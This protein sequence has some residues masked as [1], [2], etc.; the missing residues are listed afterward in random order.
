MP[1]L[2]YPVAVWVGNTIAT[3]AGSAAV[4][5]GAGG[6]SAVL[7]GTASNMALAAAITGV[8]TAAIDVAFYTGLSYAIDA[9]SRPKI[10]PSGSELLFNM[11]P[12]Y[13]REMIIGQRPVGGSMVARYSRGSNL[14][15]AHLVMQLADH[16]CTELSE[17]WDGGRVVRSTP[18]THGVRTEIT[19][20]SNSGGARVWMTWHDGRPGQTAD[21]DLVTKSAQDPDVVA[22]KIPGWSSDH[23]GA[24]C[25]YVHVEV[26]WDSDILT[27][28]PQLLFLVKGAPLYDRRKDTT[29]GGSGSHRLNDPSTWEYSTNAAVA[30]DH[31]LLGYQV[32]D[33][34]LAF[35]V[36][37]HPSEVPY[38]QFA[39]AAD[40][41]DED[42]ETGTGGDVET[43]ARYAINGVVSAAD[44]FEETIEAMQI[45]MAARVVD[46]GGRIGILGAEE[47]DIVV[48]LDEDDLVA[49]EQMQFAD[50]LG[51]ED[52]YGSVGGT[53]A[54]PAN[55]YQQTPYT[56]QYTA[57]NALP[58]GGEAQQVQ[59]AL[60]FEIHPRRAVRLASAWLSRES[61]QPRLIAR[62]MP[63]AWKLEA[64]DWFTFTS[65]RLQ[66]S[67]AK[68]EVIDIAKYDDFSVTITARAIDPEFLAFSTANDPDL[69]VPPAV[70]PISLFLDEPEFDVEVA[71]LVA[72][73][74][75]EPCLE[76]TL[77]SDETV[78]REIVVEYAVSDPA[79]DEVD[80]DE[81]VIGPTLVDSIHVSQIVTK[82]RKGILPS[83]AYRVRAKSKAGRRESVWTNWSAPL[84]TGSTYSVGSASIADAIVGQGWGA[85]A[86]QNQ[87]DNTRA[88]LGRNALYDTAFRVALGSFWR[89]NISGGGSI[90]SAVGVAA[91]NVRELEVGFSGASAGVT[92]LILDSYPQRALLPVKPGEFIEGSVGVGASIA[93]GASVTV[94][95]TYRDAAGGYVGGDVFVTGQSL[96]GYSGGAGLHTYLRLGGVGTVP[97]GAY[98]VQLDAI[99]VAGG[100]SGTVRI[101]QPKIARVASASA[102][103]SPYDPGFDSEPGADPTADNTAAAISGQGAFATQNTVDYASGLL[104]GFAIM[105]TLGH[106]YFGDG[107]IKETSGGTT[108][109][110]S[111][112]K[113][114]LGTA[115]AITSQGALA[116]LG[117]VNLGASGRVYRDDGT[118][119]LTDALAVTALGTAAA[120]TGQGALATLNTINSSGLMGSG[121]VLYTALASTAVR[122][123]TNIVRNDG[124][125]TVTDSLVITSLGVAS[126]ITSQ[127]SLA[128]LSLVTSAYL[129]AGAAKNAMYDSQ[130]AL[131][132]GSNFRGL[133]SSGTPTTSYA[134]NSGVSYMQVD[135]SGVTVGGTLII[136]D[137][138][139]RL[140]FQVKPGDVV[141]A[142]GLIGGQNC[143]AYGCSITWRSAAGGYVDQVSGASVASPGAGGGDV[144]TYTKV[145]VIGTAPA[146]AYLAQVNFI[147]VASTSSPR[148]RVAHPFKGLGKS[149]Q[150]ELSEWGP[151]IEA[152]IGADV[153]VANT[154]AAISGQG[155]LATLNTAVAIA[156]ATPSS[157]GL[158][159]SYASVVSKAITVDGGKVDIDF[160]AL[161]AFGYPAI[162]TDGDK[163]LIYAKLKRDS[164]ALV[165]DLLIGG[166]NTDGALPRDIDQIACRLAYVDTPGAGTYTY[167]I[168]LK[169]NRGPEVGLHHSIMQSAGARFRLINAKTGANTIT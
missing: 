38:A 126:A 143:S 17:V 48:D 14:Y 118:T 59:L 163:V 111:N 55:L 101:A 95:L 130:F 54:D 127:G 104:T 58:D 164:T 53:F 49:V 73:G 87:A 109:S 113:T 62:F 13:P 140:L 1:Q 7:A 26:Q 40:L 24:G 52:L 133:S 151:G 67:M 135:G 99:F 108:A 44:Y 144:S 78:A 8:A 34:E 75:V 56:T 70:D 88:G 129:G 45:Q 100:T 43:I 128:T 21:S 125:T 3:V 166:W 102:T 9:V 6:I 149:G 16:P 81:A 139:Q 131:D 68:F 28:I 11:D 137:Y 82:I 85:T 103:V 117:Q 162:T 93:G 47:R 83:T 61:L 116:T 142:H 106:V 107:Y 22:G 30:L 134:T 157:T 20:Y 167:S 12:A 98:L 123:G 115:A 152:E 138:P 114:V 90:S 89:A 97:A 122:L 37:L 159:A 31:Y 33:D 80:Q 35:G 4:A 158:T 36:G 65:P 147:G 153:T 69:S 76:F 29:A 120:F 57:Y 105:A 110:L 66:I 27:S 2:A 150:T 141:E 96:S 60:P 41:A 124:S 121:V 91:S 84:T 94:G 15:N 112:F 165:T 42:V 72:G 51:F 5:A 148:I 74:V 71:T 119:R 156:Y 168:E 77:T 160:D 132:P 23:R 64:G 63:V 161:F 169:A 145:G 25:A 32:E 86:S 92:Q 136:D 79:W 154:A 39:N 46:L 155:A 146:G 19:A 18:L 10:R 50:K